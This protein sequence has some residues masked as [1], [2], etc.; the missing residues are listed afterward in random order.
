MMAAANV[1]VFETSVEAKRAAIL[2]AFAG[3]A[4]VGAGGFNAQSLADLTAMTLA[5]A[6]P[7]TATRWVV[8]IEG[9]GGEGND[10]GPPNTATLDLIEEALANGG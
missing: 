5:P 7:T 8:V 10:A 1:Q 9:I 6:A 3:L 2:G 4:S